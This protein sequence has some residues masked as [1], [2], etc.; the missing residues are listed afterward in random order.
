LDKKDLDFVNAAAQGGMFEVQ[1]GRT[2]EQ[3]GASPDVQKI[4]AMMVTDHEK[5]NADLT[6]IATG[7]G[8]EVPATL[9]AKHKTMLDNISQKEG[10]EFDTT[11]LATMLKA[12]KA[13]LAAFQTVAHNAADPDIKAFA[14]Q[15]VPIIQTH[16]L[17]VSEAIAAKKGIAETK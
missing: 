6:K 17:H 14:Q 3:K 15:A 9:D 10:A 11:Y 1:A 4:G 8:V 7:K 12:H 16:L 2:A 13:D 5:L